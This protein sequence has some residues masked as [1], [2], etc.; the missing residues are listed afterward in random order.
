[1][2]PESRVLGDSGVMVRLVPPRPLINLRVEK[3]GHM[4]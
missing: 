4:P 1:V 3:Y 2:P